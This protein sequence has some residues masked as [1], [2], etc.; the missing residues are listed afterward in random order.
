MLIEKSK[1]GSKP[2]PAYESQR[3]S[4]RHASKGIQLLVAGK[5]GSRHYCHHNNVTNENLALEFGKFHI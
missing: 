3:R 5:T 2:Y 4:E 1:P